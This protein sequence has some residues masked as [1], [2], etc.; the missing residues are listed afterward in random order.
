[1][2]APV[3]PWLW[4]FPVAAS[5]AIVAADW[6]RT[7]AGSWMPFMIKAFLLSD[8]AYLARGGGLPRFVL[9]LEATLLLSVGWWL[10]T[11]YAKKHWVPEE[12]AGDNHHIAVVAGSLMLAVAATLVLTLALGGDERIPLIA[13]TGYHVSCSALYVV[14]ERNPRDKKAPKHYVLAALAAAAAVAACRRPI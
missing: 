5:A 1:M 8:A 7:P 12:L 11:A 10:R 3:E 2:A 9:V 4:L 13:L 6:A 14:E